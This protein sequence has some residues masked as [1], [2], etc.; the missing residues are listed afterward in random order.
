VLFTGL[1]TKNAERDPAKLAVITNEA[2]ITYRELD[3]AVNNL[4][5]HLADRGLKPGDR[6]ALHWHNSVEYVV[7]MFGLWRAGLV[8]VPINPRLKPAERSPACWST[9]ERGSVS[10]SLNYI[11][12]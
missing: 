6:V 4:A 1:L 9:Q 11:L 3:F 8:V 10:A 7:M 12:L 5:G 2:S